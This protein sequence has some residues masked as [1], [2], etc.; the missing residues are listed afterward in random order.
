MVILQLSYVHIMI[1]LQSSYIHLKII[2]KKIFYSIKNNS[3]MVIRH[4]VNTSPVHRKDER[5]TENTKQPELFIA[6]K[7]K[8]L[9]YYIS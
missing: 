4:F 6:T 2:Y 3:K 7:S 8:V 5:N 1:T 9:V